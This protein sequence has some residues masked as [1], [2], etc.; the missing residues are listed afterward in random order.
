MDQHKD[1][2]RRCSKLRLLATLL[3]LL[4]PN[5]SFSSSALTQPLSYY[6]GPKI[7]RLPTTFVLASLLSPLLL[8]K[9]GVV[10]L[11]NIYYF[12]RVIKM[13]EHL[14]YHAFERDK[15]HMR[16]LPD[17]GLQ[18]RRRSNSSAFSVA[19]VDVLGKIGHGP[20]VDQP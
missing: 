18:S 11:L 8:V 16:F 10:Y 9:M 12:I 20:T 13:E 3:V 6:L 15:S 2:L 19:V 7:S 17:R 1:S 5:P 4:E 14:G